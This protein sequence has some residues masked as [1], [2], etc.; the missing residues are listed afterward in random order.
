[1]VVKEC[2]SVGLFVAPCL[3]PPLPLQCLDIRV[4]HTA[5][6]K[7]FGG[8]VQRGLERRAR[9]RSSGEWWSKSAGA[10]VC[11]WRPASTHRF[12]FSVST[13]ASSTLQITRCLEGGCRGGRKEGQR[14]EQGRGV[15]RECRSLV[16]LG[17]CL[18]PPPLQ[19]LNVLIIHTAACGEGGGG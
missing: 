16:Y 13:F 10:L 14:A 5:D 3:H 17:P 8:R 15:V 4:I 19:C 1:V 7:V 9:G 2:R 18:H 11:L 6:Y 12:R